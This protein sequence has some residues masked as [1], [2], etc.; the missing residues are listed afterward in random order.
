MVLSESACVGGIRV[1][2]IANR[3]WPDCDGEFVNDVWHWRGAVRQLRV[4]CPPCVAT[5]CGATQFLSLS[6]AISGVES[7]IPVSTMRDRYRTKEVVVLGSLFLEF[8]FLVQID[9]GLTHYL[10]RPLARAG[11]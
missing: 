9:A 5:R 4:L 1:R 7:F 2:G 6:A 3:S 10:L 8:W 11:G